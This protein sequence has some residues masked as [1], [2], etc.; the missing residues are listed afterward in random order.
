MT[1]ADSLRIV[2][3]NTRNLEATAVGAGLTTAWA[4]IGLDQQ[5]IVKKQ[6]TAMRKKG[7]KLRPHLVP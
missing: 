6:T 4:N 7:F 3:E 2:M 1:F 5:Q